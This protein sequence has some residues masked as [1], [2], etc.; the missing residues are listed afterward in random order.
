MT[1]MPDKY[2][3]A[4]LLAAVGLFAATLARGETVVIEAA[5]YLDVVQGRMVSPAVVVVEGEKIIAI[6]PAV[7]P[8]SARTIDLGGHTLL[9]G[10][11]D[12]HT[13]L[14]YEIVEG[15]E[16]EPVRF[17]GSDFAMRGIPNAGKT[18][19]AGFTT[20]RD[21]GT[22]LG[23]SDVSLKQAIDAGWV[24]GP[25]VIPAG[26]ALS[27]TGGHCD[28]AWFAPGVEPAE[29]MSGVADGVDEVLKA[30][31][32]QIKYGAKVIKIC[33]TAGVLSF[34]G[35]AGA[36]Q[37]SIEELR[38]AADE[39]HRH[40][41]KIAAHAHGTEGI[42][43]SS[44]AGIDSIE[45]NSIMTEEAA[46]LLKKNGTFVVPNMYLNKAIDVSKLPP[47]IATK[48]SELKPVQI[49]S[50]RRALKHQLRISFG[51]DAGVFPHGENA[52]EFA[53]Q[54]ALGQTPLDAIR[55]AT[56]VNAD[57][58]GTP[59]RGRIEAGLLADLIAV[60]GNPL[61]NVALLEDVRFVMK[62]GVVFKEPMGR[63]DAAASW[64]EDEA[65]I[66]AMLAASAEAFNRGDLPGHL[67]IYDPAITFMT[68]NGPRPGIAPIE[69]AFREA[70]F[71][72]GLPK[73]LLR[74]EQLS[75][76]PLGPDQAKATGRFVLAGGGEPDQTGWFTLIWLRTSAGWRAVHDH[77]S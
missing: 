7:R 69:A 51:T 16:T 39:A 37:Y 36:Q 72:D 32:Y 63:L 61:E 57:L 77:S 50:F 34:E 10:L 52:R 40:G 3:S 4:G 48:M 12:S 6:N 27:I 9:P 45:H 24:A 59:D 75:V 73:Q 35:S 38:A 26:H 49:E 56:I 70:Y 76:R 28:F 64:N 13:H 14:N 31:R 43:A 55:S 44:Q 8:A 68:K 62:G 29:F 20:V 23:F 66:R 33:A 15:W 21:L 19:L 25:R 30:V 2:V 11:M 22:G 1:H 54:V 60:D 74:F 41:L 71:R 18:L 5:Q 53:A 58:F 67:S 65:R 17:K 42:I 47:V 46:R